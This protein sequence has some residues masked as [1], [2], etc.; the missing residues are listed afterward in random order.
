MASEP[1]RL[2]VATFLAKCARGLTGIYA[3]V[4]DT[5]MENTY[6][7]NGTTKT[8]AQLTTDEKVQILAESMARHEAARLNT[9]SAFNKVPKGGWTDA[10]RVAK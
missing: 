1:S 2:I 7:I 4:D 5:G 9:P 6:S 8:F 3:R 10:D